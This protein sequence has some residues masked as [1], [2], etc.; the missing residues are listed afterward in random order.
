M[1]IIEFVVLLG[2]TT[3][4]AIIGA[5]ITGARYMGFLGLVVIGFGGVFLARFIFAKAGIA[6]QLTIH[7]LGNSIPLMAAFIGAT[8]MSVLFGLLWRRATK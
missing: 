6:D 3:L 8:L 7:V 1:T 5:A 2:V 4:C